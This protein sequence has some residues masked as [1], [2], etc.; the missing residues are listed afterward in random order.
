MS[1]LSDELTIEKWNE[2]HIWKLLAPIVFL[3]IM[4][5]VGIPGNLTVLIIYKQKYDKSVYKS[6]IWNLALVDLMFCM[7][8]IPFNILRVV[9]YYNFNELWICVNF[10][11]LLMF[12]ILY[13]THLLMLLSI[14]RFRQICLSSKHYMKYENVKYWIIVCVCLSIVLSAPQFAIPKLEDTDLGHNITGHT[15][16]ISLSHPS[17]YSTIYTYGCLILYSTYTIILAVIYSMIGRKVYVQRK[18]AL[19]YTK[20]EDRS[21]K[22]VSL[23][24]TKV[25]FTIS[26]VFAI[27]YIPVFILQIIEKMIN[28]QDLNSVEFSTIRI[29]ERLY[30]V[31]HVAN[32]FIYAVFDSRFRQHFKKLQF[33]RRCVGQKEEDAEL[34]NK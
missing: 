34:N 27:S 21:M 6:I 23:K 24:T 15:C 1:Q 16:A 12:L 25:A 3:V 30:I 2:E 28:E 11:V 32:P 18:A 29:T 19:P 4:L 31:N 13:S 8:G 9:R 22:I 5:L 17:I 33:Y 14:Y 20:T 26:L 10:I 7:I